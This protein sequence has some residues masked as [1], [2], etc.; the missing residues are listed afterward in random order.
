MR[1]AKQESTWLLG[2]WHITEKCRDKSFLA[3][4][5]LFFFAN[6]LDPPNLSSCFSPCVSLSLQVSAGVYGAYLKATGP[7]LCVYIVLSFT[8][9]QAMAFSRGYWLSLWADD[10]VLN[11]TQ[12]HTELRVGVFGALGV[13]Q[14]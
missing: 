12:Q 14:G 9:Q 8:C 1:K 2:L 4:E 7:A 11:G 5:L 13:V 6:K 10:P 3:S